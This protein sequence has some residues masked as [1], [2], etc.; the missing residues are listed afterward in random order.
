M[1]V[2][3]YVTGIPEQTGLFEAAIV[4]ETGELELTVMV[5]G[6]EVTGFACGQAMLDVS[7]QVTISPFTGVNV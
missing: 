4:R 1:G 7:V 5:T 6:F 3:E 2:A